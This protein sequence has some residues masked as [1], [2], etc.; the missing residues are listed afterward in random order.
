M[1]TG[2]FHVSPEFKSHLHYG[3]ENFP[4]TFLAWTKI[5][6]P[7]DRALNERRL[8]DHL[9]GR[10][11]VYEAEI[12]VMAKNGE[13]RWVRLCGKAMQSNPAVLWR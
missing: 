2:M 7:D 11:P 3:E 8:M 6:H 9:E 5:I 13:L 12:R 4:G 10:E 1:T